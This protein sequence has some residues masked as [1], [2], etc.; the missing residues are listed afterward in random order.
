MHLH[1]SNPA[2]IEQFS[3]SRRFRNLCLDNILQFQKALEARNISSPSTI[4]DSVI[5]GEA[6]RSSSRRLSV[7]L[8]ELSPWSWCY[9][10]VEMKLMLTEKEKPTGKSKRAK[11]DKEALVERI[12]QSNL[13]SKIDRSMVQQL[14]QK[15]GPSI[16]DA[17]LRGVLQW[18]EDDLDNLIHNV[19]CR[20]IDQTDQSALMAIYL[21]Y[22]EHYKFDE[23]S[24]RLPL[25]VEDEQL[26]KT[27]LEPE[28]SVSAELEEKVVQLLIRHLKT[29]DG[30]VSGKQELDETNL[31]P[32]KGRPGLK[33]RRVLSMPSYCK[34]S[35]I[36]M[37]MFQNAVLVRIRYLAHLARRQSFSQKFHQ[38]FPE[39]ILCI[40]SLMSSPVVYVEW[41]RRSVASTK[42]TF[43]ELL[44][45]FDLLLTSLPEGNDK[46][47]LIHS[48]NKGLEEG[49]PPVEKKVAFQKTL[50]GSGFAL[51]PRIGLRRHEQNN[52][53][54]GT[55]RRR[56]G[57]LPSQG[58]SSTSSLFDVE[59]WEILEGVLGNPL[60]Q[61]LLNESEFV[62][63]SE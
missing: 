16:A 6:P 32:R 28:A 40:V 45:V 63:K 49:N 42:G 20:P 29:I 58:T 37:G 3:K 14:I 35:P 1:T 57:G 10:W 33:R 11:Q 54:S 26:I 61:I 7:V 5:G 13:G 24:G 60:A 39:L 36:I 51:E 4:F 21:Q 47:R 19:D 25:I 55:K 52:S 17:L 27:I 8:K 44:E 50:P 22:E 48:T 59:P 34:S 46:E 38:L 41:P 2:M 30:F 15:L 43:E 56:S 31:S 12:L 9:K 53:L 62:S 23:S 18:M